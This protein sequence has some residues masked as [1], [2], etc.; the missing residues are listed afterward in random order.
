MGWAGPDAE[1]AISGMSCL[2]HELFKEVQTLWA[3][4]LGLCKEYSSLYSL[5]C[6]LVITSAPGLLQRVSFRVHII[7]DYSYIRDFDYYHIGQVLIRWGEGGL[8]C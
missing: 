1:V 2:F 7:L 6:L 8:C 5:A 3:C 4:R